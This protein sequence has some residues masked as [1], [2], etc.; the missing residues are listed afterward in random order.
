[1]KLQTKSSTITK[2][3]IILELKNINNK[4]LKNPY[5][6]QICKYIKKTSN[7]N[8]FNYIKNNNKSYRYISY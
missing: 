2:Y 8:I 1:M 6:N 4:E 7:K 3:W 5:T